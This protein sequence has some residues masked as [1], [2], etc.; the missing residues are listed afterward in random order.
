MARARDP[1]AG[2]TVTPAI[3]QILLALSDGERHGYG[4][5]QEIA[6]RT[7][8]AFRIGPG[9]LY[10]SIKRLLA[11]DLIVEAAERPDPALDDERRRY[12]RLTERGRQVALAEAERLAHLV[13]D[14]RA[15]RLLPP[16][17]AVAAGR[18]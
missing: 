5:M 18:R 16:E 3:F 2:P 10:G 14:A 11:E 7:G 9:T 12:Y 4:I 6:A 15:K 8:G 1:A 17:P 13:A